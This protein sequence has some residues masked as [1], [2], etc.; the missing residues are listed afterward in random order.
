PTAGAE[1]EVV[2]MVAAGQAQKTIAKKKR[3][4]TAALVGGIVGALVLVGGGVTAAVVLGDDDKPDAAP[5]ETGL[6]AAELERAK[7]A[8]VQVIVVDQAGQRLGHGSGA[9]I[10]DD[11]LIITN[12]HVADPNALGLGSDDDP[13]PA[14]LVIAFPTD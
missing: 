2:P 11:G 9:L 12:A 6:S 7:L 5:A 4:K 8:T 3:R 14:G 1:I 10:S 13:D